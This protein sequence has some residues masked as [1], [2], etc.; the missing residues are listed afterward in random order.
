MTASLPFDTEDDGAPEAGLVARPQAGDNAAPFSISEIAQLLKRTVEDRFAHVKL[1]GELSGVK[2]AASGHLYCCLKDEG[3][4]IDGVMWRTASSRLSF[5]PEDGLEVIAWGKLTT[6]PGRSKYQIVIEG[7][8]I[9]GEGALL[10][11]LDK[12][13]RRL[14]AEGLFDPTRKRPLPFLPRVIGVVTSPTGAVI[15]DILHRLADRFPVQVLVWPVAVQG[16]GASAQVAAAVQGFCALAPQGSKLDANG[17]IPRPDLLIVARGGGSI[18]DLWAFNEE[19][20]VRAIAGA[21]IPTISA[22]G[23]ETDTTLADFAADLRAPTPTAAAELAVPVRRELAATLDEFALRQRRCALRPVQLGR[24]RLE[25]RTARLPRPA[26]LLALAQQ[27]LDDTAERLRRGLADQATQ[28]RERLQAD[29]A[30]LSG[31]LLRQR[32]AS[33]RLTL[34]GVGLRPALLER[35]WSERGARLAALDRLRRQ[36]DPRAPL[37]RGYALVCAPGHPVVTSRAIA[38]GRERLTLEFHDGTLTV[39]TETPAA[40]ARRPGSRQPVAS[41]ADQPKLL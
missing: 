33:A 38:E 25:Q 19:A 2:R 31:P 20:V 37:A 3:A 17:P 16:Q 39:S 32:V 24:E 26:A 36:L 13:R 29:T 5:I 8:E 21:T 6:Y 40:P 14:E 28:A 27:Q 11:L 35:E 34:A 9:A 4:V 30:R 10:A 12:T 22:I 7:M 15:R 23:H 18:E 41:R 1:R